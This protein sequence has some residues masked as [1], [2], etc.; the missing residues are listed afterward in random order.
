MD[1]SL[2]CHLIKVRLE[3]LQKFEGR[4]M[5]CLIL[6]NKLTLYIGTKECTRLTL[7][8]ALSTSPGSKSITIS[9]VLEVSLIVTYFD[10]LNFKETTQPYT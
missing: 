3:V 7:L 4:M 6:R 8:L 10:Y 9:L 5:G 1:A 2:I